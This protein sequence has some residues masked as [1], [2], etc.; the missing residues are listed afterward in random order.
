MFNRFWR[1]AARRRSGRPAFLRVEELETRT[2][3][4]V[5]VASTFAGM[6]YANTPGSVPPDTIAAAG[7]SSIIET[8]NTSVAIYNKTGG[9]PIFKEDFG[10]FFK[11]VQTG[12]AFSDSVVAYN[13]QTG[14]FFIGIL[15]LSIDSIFGTVDSDAFDYAVSTKNNPTS[16]SD[17]TMH[18]VNLT[19][20]DPAGSSKFWGDFPRIGW[21]ANAYVATFNMFTSFVNTGAE[22]YVHPLVLNVS[23]SNPGTTTLADVPGGVANATLAPATMHGSSSSDPMY[24]VEETLNSSGNPTGNS[25]R[26][27]KETNLLTSPSFSST[28]VSLASADDYLIPPNASQKGATTL[29]QTNDSRILNAEWRDNRLVA[30]QTI[31]VSSDSQAH[32]RWYEFDTTSTPSLLQDGTIGVG[33]GANSYYPSIAI[34]ANDVLGLDY[35]E[36]SSK[37]YMSVYVTGRLT[38]DTS[39]QMETAQVAQAGQGAYFGFDSSPYRAGDFSGITIDPKDGSFWAANE[40]ATSDTAHAANWGTILANFTVTNP[41]T[42]P[43]ITSIS[44]NPSTVTGTTTVLSASATD[45][46]PGATITSYT[47]SVTGPK[48]VT[49]SSSNGT[50]S[51]N[52]VTATFTQAGSYTFQVTVTDSVGASNTATVAVTVQQTVTT[53]TVSPATAIV[54]DGTTKQFTASAFDQFGNALATQP[55]FAWSL[56]AGAAGTID[57]STGIYTA[58]ATGVGSDTVRA[59]VGSVTGTA[60]AT[61]AQ[62]P[63]VTQAASAVLSSKGTT[64]SLTVSATDP[65]PGA[66]ITKYTWSVSGPTGVTFSSSNGTSTGNSATATFTQTGTYTFTATITDSYG[67]SSTSTAAALVVGQ[68]LTTIT[69][70]PASAVVPD[71]T[72]KQFTASAGDQFG[73]ALA[74]QP[75]FSWTVA[76]GGTG[77]ISS[78]GQYTA[79]VT[80][81]GTDTVQASAGAVTGTAAVTFGQPPKVSQAAKAVLSSKGTTASL[82]VTATDPN[83]ATITK[84]TWSVSGPSGVTFSSNNGTSTGNS[85]TATFTQTGTYTFTVTITDSLGLTTTSSVKLVVGHVLT[86][87][88]VTPSTATVQ[89]GQTKQFKATALDQFNTAMTAPISWK[90]VSGPGTI[91]STGLYSAPAFGTGTV[92]IEAFDGTLFGKATISLIR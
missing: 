66:T 1:R 14:Q 24:F 51:G 91:S 18:S 32:A 42:P 2:L 20:N 63:T 4:S 57:P 3:L 12:N 15:D 35:M 61:D 83:G 69:V 49:F 25:I 56:A 85:A 55:S 52:N 54:P 34:G 19:S 13:E 58:P 16:A 41:A 47:W 72:T 77:T 86:K 78:S 62:P 46:N 39:G 6:N 28:A 84:Y 59:T 70:S 10:T 67:L 89:D 22:N 5:N 79:P 50:S 21:N 45:S 31:G 9:S 40:Y 88:N 17:F 81:S 27:V 74:T 8:V 23:S 73:N 60:T 36:S 82:S 44:A 92:V 29:I 11:S 38:T 90:I 68:V 48:G 75:S 76:A 87:I 7:P 26:V 80:G 65:N 33:S 64:A 30:A 37:E 53:I 43:T 71:G